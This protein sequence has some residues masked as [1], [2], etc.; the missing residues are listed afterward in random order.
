MAHTTLHYLKVCHE[1]IHSKCKKKHVDDCSNA[2]RQILAALV[3]VSVQETA[4]NHL[5][6]NEQVI[7]YS[8]VLLLTVKDILILNIICFK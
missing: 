2:L 6:P 3:F 8:V 4:N 1:L 5:S 7:L